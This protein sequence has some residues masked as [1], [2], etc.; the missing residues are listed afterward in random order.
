M[1][2]DLELCQGGHLSLW[3]KFAIRNIGE[4]WP[5]GQGGEFA[6]LWWEQHISLN[7][8]RCKVKS[9]TC[10]GGNHGAESIRVMC[11]ALQGRNPKHS[12]WLWDS[13]LASPD[14]KATLQNPC[15]SSGIITQRAVVSCRSRSHRQT[16]WPRLPQPGLQHSSLLP[17]LRSQ[18]RPV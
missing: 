9:W 16:R 1:P 3:V 13:R 14:L 11:Q 15:L 2:A 6:S 5:W 10:T 4:A 17:A 12:E 8:T 7:P 18:T